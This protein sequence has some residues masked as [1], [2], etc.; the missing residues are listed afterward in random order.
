MH[1]DQKLQ[2]KLQKIQNSCVRFI[3]NIRKYD[4]ISEYYIK[5]NWLET[6]HKRRLF[7]LGCFMFDIIISKTPDYLYDLLISTS[8]IH[9]YNT[10]KRFFIDSVHSNYG[11][12]AFTVFGSK[13]WNN[14]PTEIKLLKSKNIF[15]QKLFTHILINN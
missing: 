13:F 1:L 4:H 11:N 5:L 6:L 15:K 10:R 9:N 2:Y 8:E 7:H 3:F 14:L 12:K